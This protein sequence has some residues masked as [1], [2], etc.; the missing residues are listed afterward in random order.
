VFK[1]YESHAP[2]L[3]FKKQQTR[4]GDKKWITEA[5]RDVNS[6]FAALDL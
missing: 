3:P 4:V 2:V 6:P 1:R 5:D